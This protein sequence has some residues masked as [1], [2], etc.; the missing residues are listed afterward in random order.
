[1]QRVRVKIRGVAPYLQ[2]RDS[3]NRTSKKDSGEGY[4]P[5]VEA[6]DRLYFDE[7]LGCYVPSCQI[8]ASM[9][10]AAKNFTMKGMKNFKKTLL[11]TVFVEEEK[12]PL[13]KRTWDE[14]DAR[15]GKRNKVNVMLWR[16]RFNDWEVE[17]HLKFSEKRIAAAKL[18]EIL[19]HAG[20]LCGLGDYIPKFGRFEVEEFEIV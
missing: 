15:P 12:L 16:P 6:R 20:E 4:V 1:M 19:C 8:E 9:R 14:I 3:G 2:S 5:E 13:G 17:F 18:K 10:E 7:K 11:A